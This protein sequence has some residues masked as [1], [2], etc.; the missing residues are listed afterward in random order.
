MCILLREPE[1]SLRSMSFQQIWNEMF[2][3]VYTRMRSDEHQCNSCNFFSLCNKCA[4][5]SQME[6]GDMAARVEYTCET[7]H[8]R[9]TELGFYDGP[10]DQSTRGLEPAKE[11]LL[12]IVNSGG[13]RS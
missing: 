6:K 11:V 2:P 9:A 4:G 1:Y 3:P 8:R 10:L 7:G 12:P 5:W 13:C